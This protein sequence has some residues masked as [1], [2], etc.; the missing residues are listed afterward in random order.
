MCAY[1]SLQHVTYFCAHT[2]AAV[3]GCDMQATLASEDGLQGRA[4]SGGW[5]DTVKVRLCKFCLQGL[6]GCV[7]VHA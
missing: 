1:V 5:D 6:S 7:F 2:Q 3:Q 4:V